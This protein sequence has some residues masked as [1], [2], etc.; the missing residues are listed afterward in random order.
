MHLFQLRTNRLGFVSRLNSSEVK[1][2]GRMAAGVKVLSLREGDSVADM[3]V[4]RASSDGESAVE[5]HVVV[6]TE[7]GF[8]KLTALS[9]LRRRGRAAKGC[10]LIRF[11]SAASTKKAAVHARVEVDQV[12]CVRVCGPDDEVVLSTLRGSVIRQPLRAIAVQSR[13]ATG[14]RLQDLA[15]GDVVCMMDVVS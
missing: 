15:L 14:V 2:T 5:T 13:A 9:D 1:R 10:R 6:V 3:D 12:R 7:Q 11:K 8:G 4:F